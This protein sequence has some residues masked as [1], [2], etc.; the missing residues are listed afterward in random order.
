MLMDVI[1]FFGWREKRR[2][3]VSKKSIDM[4]I[5]AFIPSLLTLRVFAVYLT[6]YKI[7]KKERAC[8][9]YKHLRCL[10]LG[11]VKRNRNQTL[12]PFEKIQFYSLKKTFSASLSCL[13]KLTVLHLL[14]HILV[15][16]R[17]LMV[18][19]RQCQNL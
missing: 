12:M 17:R 13:M 3:V 5:L 14:K 19:I 1:V 8:G 7:K 2:S 6:Q 11:L 15:Y 18:S 4:E 10:L 9:V 16:V